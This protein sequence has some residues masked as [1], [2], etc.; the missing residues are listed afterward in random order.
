MDAFPYLYISMETASEEQYENARKDAAL[1]LHERAHLRMGIEPF[2]RRP[3]VALTW[4]VAVLMLGHFTVAAWVCAHVTA[5]V[6]LNRLRPN[7]SG[8]IVTALL[9]EQ[10]IARENFGTLEDRRR[11]ALLA[12]CRFQRCGLAFAAHR[13]ADPTSTRHDDTLLLLP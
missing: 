7:D 12:R 9:A 11:T 8:K 5:V 2:L 10:R 3:R 4:H 13:I 1:G 6:A